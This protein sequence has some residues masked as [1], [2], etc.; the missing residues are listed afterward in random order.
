M[1]KSLKFATLLF[2]FS[3]LLLSLSSCLGGSSDTLTLDPEKYKTYATEEYAI[4]YPKDFEIKTEFPDNFPQSTEVIFLNTTNS[5]DFK[6]NINIDKRATK[7]D[8]N[9]SDLATEMLQKNAKD[10]L[11]FNKIAE[12]KTSIKVADD[13][14]D[15]IIAIFEGKNQS[16][17][18]KFKFIQVY[19]VKG[20]FAYIA[21]GT[22]LA[23]ATSDELNEITNSI[24]SFEVQ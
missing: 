15:T 22:L 11:E 8:I 18:K 21:T 14:V 6:T 19:A 24:K 2:S 4:K 3:F 13:T 5:S 17:G 20:S 23:D 7:P 1:N 16:D 10:L 9:S 12:D